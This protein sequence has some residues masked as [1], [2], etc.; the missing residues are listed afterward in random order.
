MEA[1]DSQTDGHIGSDSPLF[2]PSPF[3]FE[4]ER[5]KEGVVRSFRSFPPS[6]SPVR[7]VRRFQIVRPST[8][9]SRPPARS[10][11]GGGGGGEAALS[12]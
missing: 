11:G 5:E 6:L 2:A 7:S 12:V 10:D 1:T 9:V 4:G 8:A 3:A